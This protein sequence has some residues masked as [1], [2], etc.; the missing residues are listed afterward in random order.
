MGRYA[1]GPPGQ[2][3]VTAASATLLLCCAH[4]E[5]ILKALEDFTKDQDTKDSC[6][7]GNALRQCLRAHASR[8]EITRANIGHEHP[9]PI[10]PLPTDLP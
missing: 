7:Y 5:Q 6:H 9:S 10:G 3:L 1:Q 2:R 8:D 4:H